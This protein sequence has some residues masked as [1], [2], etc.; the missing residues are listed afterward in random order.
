M[1][2]S[3]EWLKRYVDI[4]ETPQ[5]LADLLTMLGLEAEDQKTIQYSQ[6][7]VTARVLKVNDHPNADKL[8]ICLVNDGKDDHH[9]ICGAPK[10]AE[11]QLIVLAKIGSKLQGKIKIQE[12]R[13]RGE[14]SAGMICS[15]RELGLSDEHEGII[16]LPF[17][18]PVGI[19]FSE[20]IEKKLDT[21]DLDITPNRP[22]A[23][24]HIGIAREI[25]LKTGRKL[26]LPEIHTDYPDSTNTE[27]IKVIIDDSDGCP[28]YVAGVVDNIKVGPAP[29]WMIKLLEAAGQRSINNIV[30]IS[31]FVLL[32]LGQPTHIFDF[33]LLP[34]NTIQVR[35][36]KKDEKFITLDNLEHKLNDQHL[37]IT[38]GNK[39]VAL[40]GIMG[41][42]NTAVTE[43]TKA[44]LIESAYFDPVTIRKG[45]KSLGMLTEASRRF[46]RGSDPE[47]TV[48]AFWR[49]VE[50]LRE[51][52]GGKLVSKM[53]DAYPKYISTPEIK[54]R[55]EKLEMISGFA[56]KVKQI[57][58]ILTGLNINWKKE[59]DGSWVC[60]PPSFRPDLE[61]EIDL[62]EE[63]IRFYGYDSVP[64][65]NSYTGVFDDSV[66]DPHQNYNQI[67][68]ILGSLGF[69]QC[70]NNTL[71]TENEAK[72]IGNNP[73]VII[74]PL[75]EQLSNMRTSLL[76]G[77]LQNID[78]NIKVGNPDLMLYEL[79][80]VHEQVKDGFSGIQETSLVTGIIH[81]NSK[82]V[83][84][85][86]KSNAQH[87]FYSVKGI[88]ESLTEKLFHQ[89]PVFEEVNSVEFIDSFKIT[90]NGTNIGVFGEID[91]N[92]IDQL[93]IESG[94]VFGFTMNTDEI[95]N[96][97]EN[98]VQYQ[99]PS[100]YP[101]ITRDL[102][103]VL[104]SAISAESI[105]GTIRNID[106]KLIK[107]V[108]PVD[109]YQDESL[110]N[111]KKSILFQI[112]F[113]DD[114][115]TLEDK[116]VYPIINEIINNVESQ[117]NAKLRK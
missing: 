20:Y 5:E 25:A 28:R 62:I 47:A 116:H 94:Q 9:I 112:V 23:L 6:L 61:R 97:L 3:V 104:D 4:T 65:N 34:T 101:K 63:I 12:A 74:N 86:E 7:I 69:H 115:K 17:D 30:D 44:V 14:N 36:A 60:R 43:E 107:S 70:Y 55:N 42:L 87:S 89:K 19:Q 95:L 79:G 29:D 66:T 54:L 64:I 78:Y 76:P 38:D 10:V 117:F 106:Q 21:L 108:Q 114:S 26:N 33:K 100:I 80:Q 1:L 8:K 15:E 73:V 53:V 105:I 98:Q 90:V 41:G 45:S 59:S 57:E 16:E 102:N 37:L 68:S 92:Y 50:L 83:S 88:I 40:A 113:Q 52:A 18:T 39:S 84:I 2:V 24:S 31:N 93:K 111:E 56:I 35:K 46:E 82:N 103:F 75:S 85:F 110:G 58:E 91:S 99:Q 22:D 11:N 67:H 77:L 27:K 71:Q 72:S 48:T 49:I 81:G 96:L 13:I 51:Y 32:E 109:I